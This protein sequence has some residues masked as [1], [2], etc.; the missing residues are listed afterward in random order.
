MAILMIVMMLIMTMLDVG[1]LPHPAELS[2]FSIYQGRG[3]VTVP[4]NH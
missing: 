3:S 1:V 4:D 2:F